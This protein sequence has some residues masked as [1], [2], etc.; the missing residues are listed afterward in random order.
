L[1]TL[2]SDREPSRSGSCWLRQAPDPESYSII[3]GNHPRRK[4]SK[5]GSTPRARHDQRREPLSHLLPR[6]FH[7]H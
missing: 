4:I 6:R 2:I 7:Y 3:F 5:N 1:P